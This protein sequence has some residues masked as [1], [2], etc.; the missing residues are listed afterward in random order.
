MHE[1]AERAINAVRKLGVDVIKV[2][3]SEAL[4]AGGGLACATML[5]RRDPGPSIEEIRK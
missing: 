3:Y 1:G 5:I 4:T 2:P